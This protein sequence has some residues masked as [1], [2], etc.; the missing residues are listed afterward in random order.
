[1]EIAKRETQRKKALE[2]KLAREVPF[3]G[4][5]G[6]QSRYRSSHSGGEEKKKEDEE[7]RRKDER[8]K[9]L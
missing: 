1:M 5:H 3:F 2:A 4:S 6:F 9:G 8:D 7:R